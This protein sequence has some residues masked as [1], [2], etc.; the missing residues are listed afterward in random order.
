MFLICS[1]F[2][3]R[4]L[5]WHK[6]ECHTEYNKNNIS[7]F[8]FFFFQAAH[9]GSYWGGVLQKI[10]SATVLKTIKKHLRMSSIFH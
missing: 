9:I 4:T 1:Y 6:E 2:P 3:D 7:F 5:Q 8:S 10:G